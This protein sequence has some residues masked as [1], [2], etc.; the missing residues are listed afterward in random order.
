MACCPIMSDENLDKI[1]SQA[2]FDIL[3][4]FADA[5]KRESFSFKPANDGE[6][7]SGKLITELLNFESKK[8]SSYVS[9]TQQKVKFNSASY[10]QQLKYFLLFI[11]SFIQAFVFIAIFVTYI[12]LIQYYTTVMIDKNDAV[13]RTSCL[14]YYLLESGQ[15]AR[16]N[17]IQTGLNIN[18]AFNY[19]ISDIF[20]KLT[21]NQQSFQSFSDSHQDFFNFYKTE[22]IPIRLTNDFNTEI[23]D[24][25][26]YKI[27]ALYLTNLNIVN[28]KNFTLADNEL[29]VIYYNSFGETFNKISSENYFYFDYENTQIFNDVYI[30][31]VSVFGALSI[32]FSNLYSKKINSFKVLIEKPILK[33]K[34]DILSSISAEINQRLECVHSITSPS[35]TIN[36]AKQKLVSAMQDIYMSYIYPILIGSFVI[37]MIVYILVFFQKSFISTA[38]SLN[39]LPSLQ[40]SEAENVL[41]I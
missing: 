21:T 33:M 8:N 32:V 29:F 10:F 3:S 11:V 19:S 6:I 34:D 27:I 16:L 36:P 30:I 14:V 15:G 31:V 18:L 23:S 2:D 22:K 38:N 41:K 25:N 35:L 40:L 13:L 37:I 26:I 5:R 20:N 9:H 4:K 39:S 17:D 7:M 1:E 12:V 28:G 24:Y